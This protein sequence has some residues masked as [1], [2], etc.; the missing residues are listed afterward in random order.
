MADWFEEP[1]QDVT[2][3]DVTVR[4]SQVISPTVGRNGAVCAVPVSYLQCRF[5]HNSEYSGVLPTTNTYIGG[6]VANQVKQFQG[7]VIDNPHNA[8]ERVD[9]TFQLNVERNYVNNKF[10]LNRNL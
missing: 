5:S 3:S 7:C 9:G 4:H 10:Y 6:A 1:Q 2:S 8:F